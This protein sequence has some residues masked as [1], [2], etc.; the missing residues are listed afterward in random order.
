HNIRIPNTF[1]QFVTQSV[2]KSENNYLCEDR[3]TSEYLMIKEKSARG[4]KKPGF[5]INISALMP[6][7]L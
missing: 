2:K 1:L 3:I 7:L 4:E 5:L 6:K